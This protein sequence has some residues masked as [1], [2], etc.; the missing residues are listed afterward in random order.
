MDPEANIAGDRKPRLDIAIGLAFFV[1]YAFT[2][3]PTIY[4]GDAAELATAGST[5]GI[6]HPPGYALYS[7][8]ANIWCR[9]L[10]FGDVAWRLNLMSAASAASALVFMMAFFRRAGLSPLPAFIAVAGLGFGLTFWSQALISE[11]YAFDLL[12]A[13]LALWA[14]AFARDEPRH[15]YRALFFIG[16]WCVHRNVNLLYAPTAFIIVYPALKKQLRGVKPL[17]KGLAVLLL[18]TLFWLYLPIASSADPMLDTGDPETWSRF[19]DLLAARIYRFYLFRGDFSEQL[20]LIAKDIPREIG[21]LLLLTPLGFFALWRGQRPLFWAF[22]YLLAANLFFAGNYH[23]PDYAVFVLPGLLALTVGIAAGVNRL[24]RFAQVALLLPLFALAVFNF[25]EARRTDQTLARDFA[26]DLLSPLAP[27]ALL[28]SHVDT[29][30][31]SLWYAQYVEGERSDVLTV[32]KGRAVDW[33]QA[34]ARRL[35]PDLKIPLYDGKNAASHWPALLAARNASSTPIYLTANLRGYFFP[36]DATALAKRLE[37]TPA[38]LAMRLTLREQRPN[39]QQIIDDNDHFWRRVWP[40]AQKARLQLLSADMKALLLHYASMRL[41]F[42]GYALQHRRTSSAVEA[43]EAVLALDPQPLIDRL[44]ELYR[45]R[46]ARY[47]L[48]DMVNRARQIISSAKSLEP[49]VAALNRQGIELAKKGQLEPAL[50]IF[51][52]VLKEQPQHGGAQFNRAK[53]FALLGRQDE[54]ISAYRQIIR[55]APDNKPALL[56]LAGLLEQKKPRKAIELYRRVLIPSTPA[57]LRQ[58]ARRRLQA[59]NPAAK[60]QN[61]SRPLQR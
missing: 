59:L 29:V 15:I 45:R 7:L 27:Q 30:S 47:H 57:P 5:F 37:E 13:A 8:V 33:H 51:G 16:L 26:H 53:V 38:G 34:Q 43:A 9:L 32:S 48:S 52:R 24:P 46:N 17:L 49:K 40:H 39:A 11:V 54:A 6:A 58:I 36:P 41:I 44:N 10:F 4:S 22:A 61:T 23:V 50:A 2:L 60:S 28:M 12:L 19:V 21:L 55:R 20:I 42:A 14:A 25:G 56:G 1:L 31:F 3:C 35:R 18:P